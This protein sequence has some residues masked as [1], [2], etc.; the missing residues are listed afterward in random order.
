LAVPEAREFATGGPTLLQRIFSRLHLSAFGVG[1]SALAIA[2]FLLGF[3]A[4]GRSSPAHASAPALQP[5]RTPIGGLVLPHLSQVP[6]LPTLADRASKPKPVAA[7]RLRT[8]KPLQARKQPE[9][10]PKTTPAPEKAS[11]A[12][13]K[14]KPAPVKTTPARSVPKPVVIVGSG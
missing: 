12:P 6:A 13:T 5:L 9:P 8:A 11:P 4:G 1:A 7:T 2:A 10:K 14:T 3:S